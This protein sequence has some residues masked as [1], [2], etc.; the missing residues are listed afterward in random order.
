MLLTTTI[1]AL[2]TLLTA[3][4]FWSKIGFFIS[5]V[6]T[7]L[8]VLEVLRLVHSDASKRDV[9]KLLDSYVKSRT[10][11]TSID[12]R[13]ERKAKQTEMSVS[14][15]EL[16][17]DLYM[18]P[19]PR[20]TRSPAALH[21]QSHSHPEVDVE[22][23]LADTAR[24]R[25]SRTVCVDQRAVSMSVQYQPQPS[26]SPPRRLRKHSDSL[27]STGS[28][29]SKSSARRKREGSPT[30][31]AG[32]SKSSSRHASPTPRSKEGKKGTTGFGKML[33]ARRE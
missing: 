28:V 3:P 13:R 25:S 31:M 4:S 6:A 26:Q 24:R 23:T 8:I 32:S 16:E 18:P 10:R 12:A 19:A 15:T 5:Y 30:S 2:F 27:N 1:K 29:E 21:V 9:E 14:L 20:R 7:C 22:H 17:R 11:G 33:K